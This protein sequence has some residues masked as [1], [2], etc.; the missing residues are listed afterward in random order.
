MGLDWNLI[1]NIVVAGGIFGLIFSGII[2]L[3][4]YLTDKSLISV[5]IHVSNSEE[6]EEE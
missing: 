5:E 2:A 1:F 3:L 6:E 4:M